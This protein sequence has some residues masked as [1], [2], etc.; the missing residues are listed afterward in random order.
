MARI[1]PAKRRYRTHDPTIAVKKNGRVILNRPSA[2][3]FEAAG[4][5]RCILLW[6]HETNILT[7]RGVQEHPE[8]HQ[9]YSLAVGTLLIAGLSV[10]QAVTA[11][12]R[13]RETRVASSALLRS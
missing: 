7:I 10:L 1:L 5:A 11:S 8:D 2:D 13:D 12:V 4:F 9:I 3:F 6:D